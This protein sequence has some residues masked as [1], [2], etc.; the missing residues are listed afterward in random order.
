MGRTALLLFLAAVL[1]A[2]GGGSETEPK[3]VSECGLT[4]ESGTGSTT[5]KALPKGNY[6]ATV[7]TSKGSFTIELDTAT[8][9]CAAS[10]FVSLAS[11]DFYDGTTFHRIVPGFLIQGGDPTGTGTGGPGYT[12][13]EPVPSDTR[14]TKGVVAMAKTGFEPAGT[15]G[16]QFFVV[17]AA[18]TGLPPQYAIL[19]RVVE[20]MEVVDRIGRLGARA[21][22]RPTQRIVIQDVTVAV[23]AG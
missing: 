8:S 5:M 21:T 3:A 20:G 13:N 15:S 7:R 12:T 2:C 17:T 1:S 9:P 23:S 22:E 4:V 16:S 14:Y 6:R 11:Q 19:G 10:S 18:N